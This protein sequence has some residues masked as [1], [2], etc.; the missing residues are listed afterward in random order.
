[1]KISICICHAPST[2]CRCNGFCDRH[3]RNRAYEW[4]DECRVAWSL[5][6]TFL[7][8]FFSFKKKSEW[9]RWKGELHENKIQRRQGLRKNSQ[10]STY[11]YIW[12]WIER[13]TS[14]REYILYIIVIGYG[15][16][17]Y[18]II[19]FDLIFFHTFLYPSLLT[20][21]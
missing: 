15:S 5:F 12:K 19:R 21:L 2:P 20:S 10:E 11:I 1:V 9:K 7:V 6:D 14:V 4:W 16:R 18:E 17:I 13:D 8:F 3:Q